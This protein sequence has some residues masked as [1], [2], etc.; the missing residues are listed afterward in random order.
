MFS[1][2]CEYF[3][4]HDGIVCLCGYSFN[5]QIFD[6]G[7]K[8]HDTSKIIYYYTCS[9]LMKSLIWDFLCGWLTSPAAVSYPQYKLSHSDA[10]KNPSKFEIYI[11]LNIN[12]P[13]K[14]A[15]KLS[16][17]T[18]RRS[19]PLR[20]HLAFGKKKTFFFIYSYRLAQYDLPFAILT[21]YI[22]QFICNSHQNNLYTWSHQLLVVIY[23]RHVIRAQ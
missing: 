20:V 14:I 1:A 9:Y 22:Y 12:I 5:T 4:K 15:R 17:S 16:S 21:S 18:S 11:V 13:D 10:E 23:W 8:I 6:E 19:D 2:W 7:T 3:S